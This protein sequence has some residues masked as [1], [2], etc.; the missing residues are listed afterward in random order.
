MLSSED[1][2][3]IFQKLCNK[4]VVAIVKRYF[5][6]GQLKL[7]AS[8]KIKIEVSMFTSG[9]PFLYFFFNYGLIFLIIEA[10][11]W[12]IKVKHP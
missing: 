7:H 5:Y 8:I 6:R 9:K 2:Y 4:C 3:L 12:M 1:F 10:E 11:F